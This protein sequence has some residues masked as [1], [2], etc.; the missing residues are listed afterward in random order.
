M[1]LGEV[2]GRRAHRDDA[3]ERAVRPDARAAHV[4]NRVVGDM[5]GP[6]LGEA[7]LAAAARVGM[8][9]ERVASRPGRGGRRMR[10]A[11]GHRPALGVD[12]P[13]RA[14]LRPVLHQRAQRLVQL[15]GLLAVGAVCRVG[16]VAHMVQQRLVGLQHLQRVFL[17]DAQRAVEAHLGF[18][19]QLLQAVVPEDGEQHQRNQRAQQHQPAQRPHAGLGLLLAAGD[20]DA[21]A[22]VHARGSCATR[23]SVSSSTARSTGLVRWWSK[24]AAI[25]RRR[26]SSA[27]QPVSAIRCTRPS[28][29]SA[30]KARATS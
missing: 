7:E 25:A 22:R 9:A 2:L 18:V 17:R 27:P 29:G 11:V 28:T 24:P 6:H 8:P 4:E 13:D 14:D 15:R 1:E 10:D 3:A 20:G 21:R 26:S 19:V 5:G 12:H 30:R 16:Q 23:R